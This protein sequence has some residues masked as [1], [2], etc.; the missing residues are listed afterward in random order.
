MNA[1]TTKPMTN[2]QRSKDAR[3]TSE[4]KH[5]ML[6][7]SMTNE[8]DLARCRYWYGTAMRE[9]AYACNSFSNETYRRNWI[10]QFLLSRKIYINAAKDLKS[11]NKRGMRLPN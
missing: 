11:A 4:F 8:W 2:K 10:M 5:K 6:M 1:V 3:K 7:N 9:L